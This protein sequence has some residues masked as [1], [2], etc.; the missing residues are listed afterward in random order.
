MFIKNEDSVWSLAGIFLSEPEHSWGGCKAVFID[1]A[2]SIFLQAMIENEDPPT[3][4]EIKCNYVQE[5]YDYHRVY[6]CNVNDL[7]DIDDENYQVSVASRKLKEKIS[8]S[9]IT[10][11]KISN[12]R[13]SYLPTGVGYIFRNLRFVAIKDS[14]VKHLLQN[15]FMGMTNVYNLAIEDCYIKKIPGDA[16]SH[17]LS[18]IELKIIRTNVKNFHENLLSSL[19]Q[20]EDFEATNNRI[21]HIDLKL[22][23]NNYKLKSIDLSQNVIKTING[24]YKNY[25]GIIINLERN[26]CTHSKFGSKPDD[27]CKAQL[28]FHQIFMKA[29]KSSDVSLLDKLLRCD[30]SHNDNI[31]KCDVPHITGKWGTYFRETFADGDDTET[32]VDNIEIEIHDLSSYNGADILKTFKKLT[33]E[34]SARNVI[35]QISFSGMVNLE[36]LE[37]F[38]YPSDEMPSNHFKDL[39]NL[40]SLVITFTPIKR[41]SNQLLS[42]L[43]ELTSFE[44]RKNNIEYIDTRMFQHNTKLRVID[45]SGNKIRAVTGG[46]VTGGFRLMD[47]IL[48]HGNECIN[49]SYQILDSRSVV[50]FNE[51]VSKNCSHTA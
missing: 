15:V 10:R 20:L 14:F 6:S 40:R 42:P 39:A 34:D 11:M 17:L 3:N 31:Y 43:K 9:K 4:N 8:E 16:F 2:G 50:E 27:L 51:I 48:L 13:S 5:H 12:A 7:K 29:R 24:D 28:P 36:L 23:R 21:E 1:I 41:F 32:F 25:N 44:A 46:F 22:F 30:Y 45:L 18:L 33:V 38:D 19:E 37:I 26:R 35:N 47:R 49:D